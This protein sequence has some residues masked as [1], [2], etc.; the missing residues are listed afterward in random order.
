MTEE[1]TVTLTEIVLAG[2]AVDVLYEAAS[3]AFAVAGKLP[4]TFLAFLRQRLALETAE[5]LLLFAVEHL[6]DGLLADVAEAIFGE[7]EVVAG[8]DVAV[9]LHN[10]GMAA[11]L[12]IDADAWRDAHPVG[13]DAVE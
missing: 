5:L 7:D 1:H 6:R 3:G 10:A 13:K 12:G 8:I 4:F 11:F 2:I 9:E